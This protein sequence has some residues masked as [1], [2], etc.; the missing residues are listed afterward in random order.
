MREIDSKKQVEIASE[1]MNLIIRRLEGSSNM[2]LAVVISVMVQKT[3]DFIA[4]ENKEFELIER[5]ADIAKDLIR[6]RIEREEC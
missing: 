3:C 1:A 4:K 6:I 2:N 5:I